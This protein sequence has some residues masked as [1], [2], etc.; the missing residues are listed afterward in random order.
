MFMH[1][2]SRKD[3]LAW[4]MAT[5]IAEGDKT[6]SNATGNALAHAQRCAD[7]V[8][9]DD[10]HAPASERDQYVA[11]ALVTIFAKCDM[12]N[13]NATGNAL[14]LAL[15]CADLMFPKSKETNIPTLPMKQPPGVNTV[16][17][18]MQGKAPPVPGERAEVPAMPIPPVSA[19]T[20]Q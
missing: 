16:M 5:L 9:K 8:W 19:P 4:A 12:T 11:W 7:L 15:K 2:E 13:S 17:T 18:S 1:F 10:D 14:D 6:N 20:N 3:F